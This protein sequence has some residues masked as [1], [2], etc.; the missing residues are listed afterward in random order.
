MGDDLDFE[1]E[2]REP[3]PAD[4]QRQCHV[5]Q[6][7]E[8]RLDIGL[9]GHPVEGVRIPQGQL[10]RRHRHRGEVPERIVLVEKIFPEK[11]VLQKEIPEE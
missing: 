3:A 2:E 6:I 4:K 1:P 8:R 5:R 10:A 11:G 7:E 9:K